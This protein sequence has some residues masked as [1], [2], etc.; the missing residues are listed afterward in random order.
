LIEGTSNVLKMKSMT[1]AVAFAISLEET[2]GSTTEAGPKG[3]I[4]VMGAV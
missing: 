4:Y 1:N 2:G 3:T